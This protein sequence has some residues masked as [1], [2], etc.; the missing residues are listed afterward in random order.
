MI[1]EN[2]T[3][4]T[5]GF[6][7]LKFEH[8][9]VIHYTLLAF[10]ILLQILAVI[11][12]YNESTNEAK[13][14][15]IF[16]SINHLGSVKQ[17]TNEVNDSFIN[18]Q[19]YYNNYITN[20]DEASLKEYT[21]SIN[22]TGELVDK[23][24]AV[25]ANNEEF[26]KLL[27]EK[28]KSESDVLALRSTIDSII[29]LQTSPK[30]NEAAS[31]LDFKK[32]EYKKILDSIKTDSYMKVDSVSKKGL[33]SRLGDALAGKT[34]IQKE[35]L[36]IIVTMKYNDKLVSGSIEDQIK[37]VFTT[38][39]KY[40]ESQFNNLKKSFSSLRDQD[41]KL[42]ELNSKLLNLSATILPN[43]TNPINTL[44]ADSQKKLQNQYKSNTEVR[45]YTLL[46]LIIVMLIVSIILFSFTRMAFEYENRLTIA[47]NQI[48]Q[49]LNF[50][51]R[52][53]G[54]ISH[55][56]RSPLSII[57]MYSKKISSSIKDVEIKNTFKSIQFT[58][59]SLIL[60]SNQILEYSKEENHE[61]KLKNKNF[62]L[63]SEINQIVDS[64]SSL[65]ESKG[66]KIKLNSN[67]D[68]DYEVYSDA[69]K[70]HQL[71]YNIVGNA[72]KFTENGLIS[73]AIDLDN[74]SDYEYN[75]KIEIQDSGVGIPENDLKNIFELYYQ[76]AV[77]NK[78]NDLGVG[79]GLNLCKE[80]VELFDGEIKIESEEGKGT[81][82]VFNL[83]LSPV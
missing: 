47:Q 51:N 8:R 60:L 78:I 42:T 79:L 82:V 67:L 41:L 46:I 32:F 10:V 7:K 21:A 80:I 64:L 69:T 39:N 6:T 66:N 3:K 71:F 55:E 1:K 45:N 16:D 4:N 12:W 63:K 40:Y 19:K 81:K 30:N 73:I 31:L 25:T 57:S 14:S 77:S 37:N 50:K 76:G 68:S 38:T 20:K 2:S 58:T 74:S 28:S 24:S 52:I 23:L 36:K 9:K 59:N 15:K 61:L 48:R 44:Q 83:I 35:Q 5:F 27:M 43:Y 33:F 75:L 26:K 70:I 72:N 22:K 65:V 53:M 13:V 11:F 18:S 49:S 54:M 17:L 62:H 56:I 29:A 34:D